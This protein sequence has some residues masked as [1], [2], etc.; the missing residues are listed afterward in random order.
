MKYFVTLS[1][2][3]TFLAFTSYIGF[4]VKVHKVDMAT[5]EVA[6]PVEVRVNK[7]SFVEI[8]K[9]LA[10]ALKLSSNIKV[11]VE[12]CG[13]DLV[14]LNYDDSLVT[15]LYTNSKVK[16]SPISLFFLV[17]LCVIKGMFLCKKLL[18]SFFSGFCC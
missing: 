9:K 4:S 2:F 14:E 3:Y 1:L 18:Y 6:L 17:M 10:R 7:S 12:E 16:I 13:S 15:N 8:K 5:K 11:M